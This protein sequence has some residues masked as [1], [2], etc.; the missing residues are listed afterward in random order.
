MNN[1]Q[2]T[3]SALEQ[4]SSQVELIQ[5]ERIID[6]KRA[7]GN[8]EKILIGLRG[9]EIEETSQNLS[10]LAL[11]LVPIKKKEFS[12]MRVFGLENQEIVHSSFL[13]WLLDP[14]ESHGLGSLFAEKLISTAAS[15]LTSPVLSEVDFSKLKVERERSG[16]ESRFDIRVYDSNGSFQCVFENKI[17]SGEG[18]DQTN[19]LYRDFHD[20]S[21]PRELFVFLSLDQKSKPANPH[22]VCLSYAEVLSILKELLSLAEGD[23]RF[24]IGHYSNTLE[25]LIMSKKFDGF[26]E[27]TQLYYQYFKYTEEVRKAFDTDRKLLLSALE[28]EIKQCSW[29]DEK[30]WSMEKS[31]GD[32]RIWK[33]SWRVSKNEGV[34]FQLYMHI[35]QLG[36][37]IR[38]YGEPSS[39]S[40]KFMPIIRG[41]V[42]QKYPEKVAAGLKKNFGSGVSRFLEKEIHFSPTEKNQVE[43]ILTFL[44][45]AVTAFDKI[46]EK[47]ISEYSPK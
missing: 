30:A 40:A 36:F 16:D 38:I 14:L 47:S 21:Y 37:S 39:F 7:L 35:T 26:S 13:A 29:W 32:I 8:L 33:N 12:F 10:K 43:K 3:R 41:L 15:K 18:A 11:S 19:R 31:G 2:E 22:F 28:E 25:R 44:N 23:T 27:R 17:W 9:K 5:G 4:F 24:L 42:N 20:A 6:T 45:E 1:I 46:I 34:F